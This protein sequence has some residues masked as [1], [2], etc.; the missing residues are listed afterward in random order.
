[1]NYKVLVKVDPVP[2]DVPRY[3]LCG[4]YPDMTPRV[5]VYTKDSIA[6]IGQVMPVV[7]APNGTLL[8]G[9]QRQNIMR[10]LG[11]THMD[12]LQFSLSPVDVAAGQL[13]PVVLTADGLLLDGVH[14]QMV[15]SELGIT[16][17]NAMYLPERIDPADGVWAL[18]GCRRHMSQDAMDATE[19]WLHALAGNDLTLSTMAGILISLNSTRRHMKPK[20]LSDIKKELDAIR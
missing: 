13:L 1:M 7:L 10:E 2:I 12:A 15:M 9:A 11:F 5:R 16:G 4:V 18:N 19:A 8:D 3:R 14:R 6:A 17:M 20:E